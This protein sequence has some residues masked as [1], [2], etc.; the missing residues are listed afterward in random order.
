MEALEGILG[1]IKHSS[2]QLISSLVMENVV[3]CGVPVVSVEKRTYLITFRLPY[4]K[5]VECP[6]L[7][8]GLSIFF[9]ANMIQI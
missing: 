2:L 7:A 3:D 1:S 5:L 4:V 8:T 6:Y 9:A